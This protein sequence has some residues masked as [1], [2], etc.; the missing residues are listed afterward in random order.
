VKYIFIFLMLLCSFTSFSQNYFT[1]F[2]AG[3]SNYQG[4]LSE[5][6]YD[7]RHTH[8]GW[9]VGLLLELNP[10]MLIRGD[11]TYGRISGSDADGTKNRSR[12]L[13]FTSGISEFSL[14]FEYVLLD[15][16]DYQF[17]P[18]FFI[19]ASVFK[20]SPYAK[21]LNGN[22][23]SLYEL[24]TEGQGFYKNRKPYK[25]DQF[26][27]PIGGGIQWAISKNA[28]IGFVIGVRQTFTDYL[29]DV[30]KTYVD[31]DLLR[32]MRGGN[33]VAF[34][35]RGNQLSNGA[36]YPADGAQRGNPTNKD[37]YYFSGLTLR[38]RV[39]YIKGRKPHA[40]KKQRAKVTC[41]GPVL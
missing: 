35:Y 25:L 38:V 11:F 41:P 39:P 20:F 12:N 36:P 9:G 23:T 21:D 18:Y 28:R 29:D 1:S 17:S 37:W 34:A 30:S 31:Q 4:D 24:N 40:Y 7:P 8:F 33:A 19:G 10:H 14:G 32:S 3:T 5:K 13:N 16:Y 27:I 22:L 6:L 15:L 2:Y 26:A